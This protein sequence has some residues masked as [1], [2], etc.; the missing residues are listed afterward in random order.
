MR[1]ELDGLNIKDKDSLHK[2]LKENFD[3]PEHYGENL[4]ALWDCLTSW[5]DL[6]IEL[7]WKN[8]TASKTNLGDYFD[9]VIGLFAE[10]HEE[11]ERFT[12]VLD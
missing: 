9:K 5:I 10:V 3:L 7:I 1:V 8:H 4:D 12:F 6:P 11:D 2:E